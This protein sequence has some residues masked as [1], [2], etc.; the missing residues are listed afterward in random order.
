MII[1][2]T[3]PMNTMKVVVLEDEDEIIKPKY[4]IRYTSTL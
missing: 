2:I 3:L 4:T 1:L